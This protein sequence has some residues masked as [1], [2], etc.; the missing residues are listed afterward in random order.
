MPRGRRRGGS[1]ALALCATALTRSALALA[2]VG[3]PA[4]AFTTE[5]HRRQLSTKEDHTISLTDYFNNQY[6]GSL[7]IGTPPQ[8][9]T[10]V[11]DIGSSDLWLPA[12]KCGAKCGKHDTFDGSK[13]STYEQVMNPHG[14]P[15]AFEVDYGSGRV[16]GAQARDT[17]TVGGL[18][19]EK[20]KFGEV[21][22]E[23][24]EIREFMMD[25][26]AGMAFPGLAMVTQ[27]TLLELL[28][29]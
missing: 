12:K 18:K 23:D 16:T 1:R 25:G 5:L 11:F 19:I 22:Y 7:E 14:T 15:A 24:E 20:V 8:K 4:A 9:L 10:V 3:A 28:H 17:V 6:V 26:I 27:P 29:E 13:S 2:P 21:D